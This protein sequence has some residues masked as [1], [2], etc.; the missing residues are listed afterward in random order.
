VIAYYVNVLVLTLKCY[1]KKYDMTLVIAMSKTVINSITRLASLTRTPM[2]QHT[3]FN[4]SRFLFCALIE[5]HIC[6]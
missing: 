5:I 2:K 4:L 1:I 3:D 6:E